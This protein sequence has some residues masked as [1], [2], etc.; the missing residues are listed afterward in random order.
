MQGKGSGKGR[1]AVDRALA[2]VL[3]L[4]ESG[5]L[6]AS[7][8]RT[9]ISR[10]ESDSPVSSWSLG[11]RLLV[12]MAGTEDARGYR[13][14]QAAGRHVTK[15]SKAFHILAPST[16]KVKDMD[17]VT[18]EELERTAVVG[19]VGVPVFA[20]E[21]TE[22]EPIVR[23]DYKPAELPPLFEV[24]ARLGV[25]VRWLPF[26]D[27]CY[28]YYS[29]GREQVVLCSADAAVFW[30]ELAHAAHKR[31][32]SSQGRSLKGGQQAGQEVVAETCAAVIARLY[33]FELGNVTTA[34]DYIRAYSGDPAKAVMRVLADVQACLD[35]I[36][37]PAPPLDVGEAQAR[38]ETLEAELAPVFERLEQEADGMFGTGAERRAEQARRNKAGSKRDRAGRRTV[39]EEEAAWI[40]QRLSQIRTV[41]TDNPALARVRELLRERDELAGFVERETTGKASREFLAELVPV[42]A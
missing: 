24:A 12:L 10:L 2:S 11:N 35:L 31:V 41:Q 22:G 21:S 14:W 16:R 1:E 38:L 3:E 33:D 42:A 34:A 30:H 39:T 7:V 25:E 4:F 36:L 18:G 5:E 20:V 27:S 8:A 6:P 15:G 26:A 9:T 29:P 19:F 23:P 17:P 32:L 40:G 37:E 13:Q 28:G